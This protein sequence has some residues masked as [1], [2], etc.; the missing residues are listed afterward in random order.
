MRTL[1]WIGLSTL[2]AGGA[3]GQSLSGTVTAPRCYTVH[4]PG[5]GADDSLI[6]AA[7]I[8]LQPGVGKGAIVSQGFAADSLRFW[9]MF[10]HDGE[11][12]WIKPDSIQLAFTNG[13]TFITYDLRVIGD[14]L[15]GP[16]TIHYDFRI[17]GQADPSVAVRIRP[18]TCA[19]LPHT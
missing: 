14:T 18:V 13:F 5:A 9:R 6:L 2:F 3:W 10:R 17:A 19:A 16:A 7:S 1:F 15:A 4:Y 12:A 11:W 8:I